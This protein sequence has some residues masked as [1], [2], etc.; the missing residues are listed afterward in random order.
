MIPF[1]ALVRRLTD[2]GAIPT[3]SAIGKSI[4]L[5]VDQAAVRTILGL[6]TWALKSSMV[7]G[8]I[9]NS[10]ITNAKLANMSAAT[11]MGR[12]TGTGAPEYLTMAQ[13]VALLPLL[14][15]TT[16]GIAPI[17]PN[18]AAQVL[19][20]TGVWGALAF[21][22]LSGKPTSLAGYGIVDTILKPDIE[23]QTITG[24]A[25][26]TSKDLGTLTTGTLTLDPGDRPLQHYTNNGAHA[27]EP[28][29]NGG[30]MMLDI[31]NG[32]SAGAITTTGWTKVVG[33]AFT[34]TS[35]HKFRCHCSVGNGGALLIVQA[36]Q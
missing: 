13:L 36:M 9:P 26:V 33:D 31:I 15:T 1:A 11:V 4:S 14:S 20:G 6:G 34:L 18:N 29:T 3:F 22:A 35:G 28:G 8:D 19:L 23:D 10:L 24:G 12:N 2:S 21:S 7:I 30:S 27:L 32:A 25:R 5:A 17:A 16:R